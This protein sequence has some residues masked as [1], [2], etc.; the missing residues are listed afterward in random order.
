VIATRDGKV[1]VCGTDVLGLLGND[2][3]KWKEQHRFQKLNS[4]DNDFVIQVACAEFHSL[5][6]TR[7]GHIFA[8]GGNLS[9]VK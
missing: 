3:K 8:W 2:S 9:N 6:L 7:D 1:L 4:L 5:C